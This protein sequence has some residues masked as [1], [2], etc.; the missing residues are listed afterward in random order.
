MTNF[1]HFSKRKTTTFSIPQLIMI[2]LFLMTTFRG[3]IAQNVGIGTETPGQKLEVNGNIKLGD[4]MMVE[5]IEDYKIYR[6]VATYTDNLIN[7]P[8][9]FAIITNQPV[10]TMWRMRVEGR[11]HEGNS[12]IDL[13]IS[14]TNVWSSYAGYV[15]SSNVRLDVHVAAS[16]SGKLVVIIG[17]TLGVYDYPSITVSSFSHASASVDE[18]Y[19][20]GWYIT[21][22][23]ST[24]EFDN[25]YKLDDD[26]YNDN[27]W[28]KNSYG[29]FYP[30]SDGNVGINYN[31]PAYP[32]HL[33]TFGTT[34]DFALL[35]SEHMDPTYTDSTYAIRGILRSKEAV[36]PGAAIYGLHDQTEGTSSGIRGESKSDEGYGVSGLASAT[37]GT[38]Y[39]VFGE[40][41]SPNGYAGFF[42]GGKNY[43]EGVV[44][45][46]TTSPAQKLH[47]YGGD[48]QISDYYPFIFFND[49]S[50]AG[51][52]GLEFALNGTTKGYLYY[53]N[54]DNSCR[55]YNYLSGSN[56]NFVIDSDGDVGIGT[57]S[58]PYKLSSYVNTGT[59]GSRAIFGYN[60][61]TGTNGS[62]SGVV[63]ETRTNAGANTGA[64][65]LGVASGTSGSGIGVKGEAYGPGSRGLYGWATHTTGV[66]YGVY[67][68]TESSNGY[69][70]YFE[71]GKNYFEGSVGI[72]DDAPSQKLEVA[73][74]IKAENS[75]AYL[76][77]NSTNASGLSTITFQDVG[78]SKKSIY[79]ECNVDKLLFY[80]HVRAGFDMSILSNGDVGIGTTVPGYRLDVSGGATRS[81][82]GFVCGATNGVINVGG[83]INTLANVIGDAA[84]PTITF[85]TGDEDLFIEDDLEV[86]GQ[87]Y[88]TGGGSWVTIS[89]ARLKKDVVPFEDGLDE[90]LRIEP[91]IYSY[92][93]LND[94]AWDNGKRYVGVIAQDIRRIAPY[95][96][97][98]KALGRVVAENEDGSETL[99]NAGTPYLTFD[100]SALTYMLIN[101]IKDQQQIIEDQQKQIDELYGMVRALQQQER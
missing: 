39:G 92:N 76:Y 94:I 13:V 49:T 80:D 2:L 82:T 4:H 29:I 78:T 91:V 23:S 43:F 20:D 8:G 66:N 71:G 83:A 58:P 40:T 37:S 88:K 9:A 50:T 59:T 90:L 87:G 70:A 51:N 12:V 47:V 35:Q 16:D 52:S 45:I 100:G 61:S 24:T 56:D 89:D 10:A 26:T 6:N 54:S 36:Y 62:M 11:L 67:G 79:Y 21:R 99:I 53:S 42:K 55:F 44:G 22:K 75:S 97:E 15:N 46:G 31:T 73:G 72:G 25:M 19:A 85:A 3:L 60:M 57:I 93:G 86:V 64:G 14:G 74:N 77:L 48:I 81:A 28:W 34:P 1:D 65:V 98:E 69:A 30:S 33:R 41:K 5:G 38:N 32:L 63:G 18:A 96:V 84:S 17:D 101:S 27:Y 7:S 95:M 68:K